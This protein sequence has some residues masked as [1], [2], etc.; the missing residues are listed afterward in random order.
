MDPGDPDVY[1]RVQRTRDG[2]EETVYSGRDFALE[3]WSG[4]WGSIRVPDGAAD[5]F[6]FSWREGEPIRVSLMERDMVGDNVIADYVSSSG[7]SIILVSSPRISAR[8]HIVHLESDFAF[9]K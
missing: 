7:V 4:E 9:G 3:G 2:R 5:T 8:G 1:L 6:T